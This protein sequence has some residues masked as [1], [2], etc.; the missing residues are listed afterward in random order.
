[1]K[2]KLRRKNDNSP[3]I[4]DDFEGGPGILGHGYTAACEYTVRGWEEKREK[5]LNIK[6]QMY[7]N[8]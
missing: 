4:V 8:A 6:S 5:Q 7:V 3:V 2:N 1:M